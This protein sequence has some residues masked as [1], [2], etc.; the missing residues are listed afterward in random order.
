MNS[1]PKRIIKVHIS[2]PVGKNDLSEAAR[3]P[4]EGMLANLQS[5]GDILIVRTTFEEADLIIFKELYEI[6][7]IISEDKIYACM[8]APF[9]ISGGELPNNCLVIG[10]PGGPLGGLRKVLETTLQVLSL[11]PDKEPP[12]V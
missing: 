7:G 8:V 9:E 5:R 11:K 2:I 10:G 3:K 4:L 6:G 12:K 1:V